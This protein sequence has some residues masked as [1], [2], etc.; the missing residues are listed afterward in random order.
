MALALVTDDQAPAGGVGIPLTRFPSPYKK[1]SRALMTIVTELQWCSVLC[2]SQYFGTVKK[3][4]AIIE[5]F[6][7]ITLIKLEIDLRVRQISFEVRMKTL[8]KHG[9][10][11]TAYTV[12]LTKYC[13]NHGARTCCSLRIVTR[14]RFTN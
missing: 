3:E 8:L 6:C 2:Y 12:V 10:K 1:Q 5:G 4:A 13:L 9:Q 7:Y 14:C 11:Y